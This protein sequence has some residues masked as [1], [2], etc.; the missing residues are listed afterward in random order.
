MIL[1]RPPLFRNPAT[2][3]ASAAAIAPTF[4]P[5]PPPELGRGGA[6]AAE[7]T[8]ENVLQAAAAAGGAAAEQPT[9]HVLETAAS[10]ASRAFRQAAQQVVESAHASLRF[11]KG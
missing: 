4:I 3:G 11:S 2:S 8:A 7:Q 6:S 1:E 9:E 10:A 5:E